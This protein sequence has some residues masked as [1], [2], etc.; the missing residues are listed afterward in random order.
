MKCE[1][2]SVMVTPQGGFERQQGFVVVRCVS[3]DWQ[4]E[5]PVCA[6]QLCPIGRIEE[7]RDR[8]LL[9]ITERAEAIESSEK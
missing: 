1:L 6:T 7:A 9:A 5:G 2:M 4:F 8:A 3:H